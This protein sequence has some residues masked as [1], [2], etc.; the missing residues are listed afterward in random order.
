M[1]SGRFSAHTILAE[2]RTSYFGEAIPW[3]AEDHTG[4]RQTAR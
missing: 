2:D 1:T 4:G 3:P